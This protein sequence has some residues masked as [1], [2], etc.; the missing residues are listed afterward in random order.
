MEFAIVSF[1]EIYY[2]FAENI[3]VYET[4]AAFYFFEEIG[5]DILCRPTAFLY[6]AK[7]E[8]IG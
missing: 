6:R 8:Q 3:F 7:K 1:W 4:R 2:T 5:F